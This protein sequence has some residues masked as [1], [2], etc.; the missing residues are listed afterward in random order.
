MA[1]GGLEIGEAMLF[2]ISSFEQLTVCL[3]ISVDSGEKICLI[4]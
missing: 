1:E 4:L 3:Q 2:F